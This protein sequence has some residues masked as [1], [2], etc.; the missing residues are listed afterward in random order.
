MKKIPLH[1]SPRK[2]LEWQRSLEKIYGTM[3]LTCLINKAIEDI[4]KRRYHNVDTA[5]HSKEEQPH[6]DQGP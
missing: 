1:I 3:S 5:M 6:D 2:R 4:L